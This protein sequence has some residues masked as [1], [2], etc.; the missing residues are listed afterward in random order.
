METLFW[1]W[2]LFSLV[3]QNSTHL[4]LTRVMLTVLLNNSML[5]GTLVM[6]WLPSITLTPTITVLESVLATSGLKPPGPR[7]FPTNLRRTC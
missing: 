6:S 1:H 3:K 2:K 7:V 5:K 4:G